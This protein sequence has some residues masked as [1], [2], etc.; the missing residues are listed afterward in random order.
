M[1]RVGTHRIPQG[2]VNAR[3]AAM[4]FTLT[5]HLPTSPLP[6]FVEYY[7]IV[8]WDLRGGEPHE[9]RVLPNLSVHAAF[10]GTASGGFGPAQQ[11]GVRFRAGC[12]RPFLR[13]PVHALANTANPLTD[14]FGRPASAPSRPSSA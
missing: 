14:V 6:E 1:L 9:Q 8:R 12:F 13:R 3:L 2:I 11:V 4:R 10:S 5:R 7:W